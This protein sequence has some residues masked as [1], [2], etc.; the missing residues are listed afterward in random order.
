V[1]KIDIFKIVM[2]RM[3]KM[4]EEEEHYLEYF[5]EDINNMLDSQNED[6]MFGTEGQCDPRGDFRDGEWSM[7]T[8]IQA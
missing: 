1:E 3:I 5:V 6:D 2:E 4:A 7:L 8:K